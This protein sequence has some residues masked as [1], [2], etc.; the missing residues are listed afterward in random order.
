MLFESVAAVPQMDGRRSCIP[1]FTFE[2]QLRAF[3]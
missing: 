1:R 2:F 3:T